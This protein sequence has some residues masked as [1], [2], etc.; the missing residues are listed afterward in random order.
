MK[1]QERQTDFYEE[2]ATLLVIGSQPE[3]PELGASK[4]RQ[5]GIT[6]PILYDPDTN[7][8]RRLGLWSDRMQMPFMGY[9][10]V[11]ETG[12]IVRG[13]QVLSEAGGSASDNIDEILAALE[14]AQNSE[15]ATRALDN[16]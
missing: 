4:A 7:A 11:D 15:P 5:H 8:T 16:G 10:I 12:R 3:D 14:D 2:G 1:L 13:D 6:Y 9:I